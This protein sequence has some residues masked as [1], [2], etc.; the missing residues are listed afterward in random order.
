[1]HLYKRFIFPKSFV[2]K[3][4]YYTQEKFFPVFCSRKLVV[5]IIHER[6]SIQYFVAENKRYVLSTKNS[7]PE[8][9]RRKLAMRLIHER[10]FFRIYKLK[11]T[12]FLCCVLVWGQK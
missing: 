9:R 3:N 4:Q 5:R 8:F 7:I 11:V 6:Q 12:N 1:M 10:F 2:A